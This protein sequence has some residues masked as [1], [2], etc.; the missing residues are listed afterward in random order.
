MRPIGAS[1]S[2]LSSVAVDAT[3]TASTRPS[4]IPAS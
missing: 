2:R 3:G 1:A 4:V